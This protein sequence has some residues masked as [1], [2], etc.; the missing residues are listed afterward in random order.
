MAFISLFG[1]CIILSKQNKFEN[2]M[3]IIFIA[4]V[5]PEQSIEYNISF[6]A[7]KKQAPAHRLIEFQ[8]LLLFRPH[9]LVVADAH[10]RTYRRL[11]KIQQSDL[12]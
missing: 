11:S 4:N 12:Q 3:K 8:L 5:L 7:V 2:K 10:G 1:V 6:E 9:F